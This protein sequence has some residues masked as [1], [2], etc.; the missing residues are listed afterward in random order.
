MESSQSLGPV[1]PSKKDWDDM[2]A[3]TGLGSPAKSRRASSALAM[4]LWTLACLP[5]LASVLLASLTIRSRLE[6]GEWPSLN[7]PDPKVFGFHYDLALIGFLA[8]F[9]AALIVP[10]V[11]LVAFATGHRRV[12][13]R[14]TVLAFVSF[15]LYFLFVRFDI[16]GIGTW[17]A[18]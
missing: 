2:T 13:I 7:Q 18:D 16:G 5:L 15:A 3:D 17:F 8:A 12:T 9:A 11:A 4:A 6:N 10:I 14:P 1:D